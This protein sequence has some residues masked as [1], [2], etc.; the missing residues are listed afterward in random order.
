MHHTAWQRGACAE[1]DGC[2]LVVT[3]SLLVAAAGAISH[4]TFTCGG[5]WSHVTA[6]PESVRL[7]ACRLRR[8]CFWTTWRSGGR[9]TPAKGG[10]Q[11]SQVE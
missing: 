9:T 4:E 3:V 1:T 7:P 10:G 5:S 6:F 8:A 11:V 2:T